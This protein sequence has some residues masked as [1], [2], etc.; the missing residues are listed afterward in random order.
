M[1]VGRAHRAAAGRRE[2]VAHRAVGRDRVGL[3]LHGPEPVAAVVVRVQVPAAA[4]LVEVF[5]LD[6]VEAV[7]VGLPDVE[8]RAGD[9]LAVGRAHRAAHE[10]RRAGRAVG[11]VV[12]V[13]EGGR[14][15]DE[16]G[17]EDGRLGGAGRA[18]VVHAHHEHRQPEGVGGEDELLAL[19]VGDVAGAREEVDG[20]EPLLLGELDLAG[21][22]V[23]VA[24][25]RLQDLAQA[26]IG[27]ALEAGLDGTGQV[28]VG[29]V[30]PLFRGRL[31]GHPS[32]FARAARP[33]K[34]HCT[35]Y[36]A[37][38]VQPAAEGALE[39]ARQRQQRPL[40]AAAAD[41]LDADGEAA[42]RRAPRAPP[43]AGRPSALA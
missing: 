35:V 24:H 38:G 30:A 41:E 25:Q 34:C 12:A 4:R 39:L 1:H 17:A 2:H 42:R 19:V 36:G 26:G 5:V 16:E 14:A 3:G 13:L 40:V 31:V 6:V 33:V 32:T 8:Q 15:L 29:E 43:R 20:G 37:V 18:A 28:G 27:G 10:A 22:G 9:R 7:L 23:Q 11:E 21:E